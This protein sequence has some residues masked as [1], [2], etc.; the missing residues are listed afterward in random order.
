VGLDL[1]PVLIRGAGITIQLTLVSAALALGMALV[2]GLAR[3]SPLWPL[4]FAAGLY[5]A[6]F[7]G[8]SVLVQL[9][10]FYFA[11]PLFGIRLDAF[12][13]GVLALGLNVGAYGA[14]VVRGAIR[15]VP[16]GQTE[17][18]IALNFTP[19]QRMRR[20]I[21]PQAFVLMLP[22]FGNQLIELLKATALVSLITIPEMTFQGLTLRQTTGRTNEIFLWLLVLYFAVAYPL[23]LGV[24][25]IERRVGAYTRA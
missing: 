1:L 24:R 14:E 11:L 10:W 25:W 5:V 21:L 20:I 12:T 2:A 8:T 17:A 7:R 18:A 15:S 13:A 23:T 6:V 19:W 3:L 4:R 22:P 16:V 9:F